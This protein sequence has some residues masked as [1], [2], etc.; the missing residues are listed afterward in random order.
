MLGRCFR[1]NPSPRNPIIR[2]AYGAWRVRPG[3]YAPLVGPLVHP[4]QIFLCRIQM[5]KDTT[6]PSSETPS[7]R[8]GHDPVW[9]RYAPH[10][11]QVGVR[12]GGVTPPLNPAL[13]H[14]RQSSLI[15]CGELRP[16]HPQLGLR[17]WGVAPL[18]CAV[19]TCALCTGA[20]CTCAVWTHANGT[21]ARQ[22]PYGGPH[23]HP[24]GV[25]TRRIG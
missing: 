4:R 14:P 6:E 5:R 10:A 17:Q 15:L 18:T 16:P 12:H 9:G 23:I 13:A 2:Q 3:C 21:C 7:T 25:S 8:T 24:L 22:V 11:P 1:G 19:W 20:L